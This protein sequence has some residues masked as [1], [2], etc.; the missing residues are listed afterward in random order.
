MEAESFLL[1]LVDNL[2]GIHNCSFKDSPNDEIRIKVKNNNVN[3]LNL[4]LKK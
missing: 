4:N 1:R 3:Y 2:D